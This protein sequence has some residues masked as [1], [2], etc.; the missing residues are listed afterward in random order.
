MPGSIMIAR[1]LA[2]TILSLKDKL[3]VSIITGPW[4][5]GKTTLVKTIFSVYEYL[6]LEFPDIRAQVLD[7][8]RLF[9]TRHQNGMVIDEVQRIP[10]L[11]SYIQGIVAET[12]KNGSFI[13]T[14]SQPWLK[15]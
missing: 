9:L 14:G 4:Q 3:P 12:G 6:N 7:D 11:F 5:A 1:E 2:K 8:P 15:G 13:L 10:A